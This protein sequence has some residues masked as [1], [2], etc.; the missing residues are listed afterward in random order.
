MDIT[1]SLLSGEPFAH[2]AVRSPSKNCAPEVPLAALGVGWRENKFQAK[3]MA[4]VKCQQ[5]NPHLHILLYYIRS[6]TSV[7]A[8]MQT[9]R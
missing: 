5:E 8:Q 3:N 7:V 1:N 9:E 4:T 2:L 6:P